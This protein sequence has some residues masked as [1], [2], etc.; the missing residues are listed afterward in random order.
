MALFIT[1]LGTDASLSC[2]CFFMR[3]ASSKRNAILSCT[4]SRSINA[5]GMRGGTAL[6]WAVFFGPVEAVVELCQ[7]QNVK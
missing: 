4:H 7:A 1:Q 5:I 2:V 6:H 3:Q